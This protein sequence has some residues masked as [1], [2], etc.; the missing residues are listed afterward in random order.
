MRW[1]WLPTF[2]CCRDTHLFRGCSLRVSSPFGTLQAKKH[3]SWGHTVTVCILL[4]WQIAIHRKSSFCTVVML[5][6]S[7]WLK[8]K[9]PQSANCLCDRKRKK[10]AK[11]LTIVPRPAYIHYVLPTDYGNIREGNTHFW[12]PQLVVA[13]SQHQAPFQVRKWR[14]VEVM[15]MRWYVDAFCWCVDWCWCVEVLMCC[16]AVDNVLHWCVKVLMGWCW[17]CEVLMCLWPYVLMLLCWCTGV[18]IIACV[19]V[20]MC[21]CVDVNSLYIFFKI[22]LV[23]EFEKEKN[24]CHLERLILVD[25]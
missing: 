25:S 15:L 8:G 18:L 19:D 14:G 7:A 6:N 3:W 2:R 4:P 23:A 21:W 20:L 24:L 13:D 12:A 22:Q 5:D 17:D 11:A 1:M 10:T 9:V 16:I